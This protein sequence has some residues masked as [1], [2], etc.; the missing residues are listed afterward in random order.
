MDLKIRDVPPA[1]W[2]DAVTCAA[3]YERD[4]PDRRGIY[5]G[6]AYTMKGRPSFYV[7]RTKTAI[8]VRGEDA[9]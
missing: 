4:Y 1:N 5:N 7:Y 2:Q 6:A 8:V 9:A 3:L